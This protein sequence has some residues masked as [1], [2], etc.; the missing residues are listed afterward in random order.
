MTTLL[1]MGFVVLILFLILAIIGNVALIGEPRKPLSKEMATGNILIQ[2]LIIA[3][4]V[5]AILFIG[6]H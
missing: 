2:L 4:S 3:L 5:G 1:I 6:S